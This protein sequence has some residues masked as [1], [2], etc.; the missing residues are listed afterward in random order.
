M[1]RSNFLKAL[2]GIVAGATILPNMVSPEDEILRTE[3]IP[4]DFVV[5]GDDL[6]ISHGITCDCTYAEPISLF[7]E[8]AN[9]NIINITDT[10]TTNP[11]TGI[12]L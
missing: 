6:K 1:K 7:C 12:K 8:D 4:H 3:E 11:K 10:I 9:G 5:G 2:I